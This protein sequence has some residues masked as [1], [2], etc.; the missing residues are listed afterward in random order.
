[1]E[2][3]ITMRAAIS[4]PTTSQ[5]TGL[6]GA[7]GSGS[8]ASDMGEARLAVMHLRRPTRRAAALRWLL[9]LVLLAGAPAVYPSDPDHGIGGVA[10][11]SAQNLPVA[12]EAE[13]RQRC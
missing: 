6:R 3:A 5:R 9:A 8:A 12:T 4:T 2:A 10:A 11:S 1:M 13:A 7:A